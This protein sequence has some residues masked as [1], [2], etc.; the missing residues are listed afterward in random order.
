MIAYNKD[1]FDKAGIPY[2]TNDWTWDD[3]STT[4]KQVSSGEG[5]NRVYGIVSHWI[6][7][8]FAPYI[9]GGMPYNEDWSKQTLDDPN[10]LKGTSCSETW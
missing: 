9:Y 1:I 5:A 10:T 7:Q 6:L 2:P 3:F 8:S 4:A